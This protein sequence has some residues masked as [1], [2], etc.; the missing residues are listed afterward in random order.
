MLRCFLAGGVLVL[1]L[2]LPPQGVAWSQ[3]FGAIERR[4]GAAV[5]EGEIDLTQAKAMLDALRSTSKRGDH[6][7][8]KTRLEERM[9]VYAEMLRK[10][11]AA[12]EIS[13]EEAIE[14]YEVAGQKIKAHY[15]ETV[16]GAH[17]PEPDVRLRIDNERAGH[18]RD[19]GSKH[20][21]Q[22]DQEIRDVDVSQQ[23][24]KAVE[25]RLRHHGEI[26]RD[27]VAKG[28]ISRE[29]ME[30]EYRATQRRIFEEAKKTELQRRQ[31]RESSAAYPAGKNDELQELRR[32]IE[33][34]IRQNGERLRQQFAAG[35][36]SQEEMEEQYRAGER[37]MLEYYRK[38]ELKRQSERK[39]QRRG[40]AIEPE[41]NG[42]DEK[43]D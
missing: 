39:E 7:N 33:T 22:S 2:G 15:Q 25:Q 34:R 19:E 5:A 21:H 1:A 20:K 23:L 30:K 6:A 16:A 3:D 41:D 29:E 43:D 13:K 14:M 40:A 31:G 37:K 4:L 8:L 27:K 12:G 11:V 26:L 9:K 36:I 18:S 28:E 38:A 10:Q 32:G 17:S 35:E 24:R 42:V